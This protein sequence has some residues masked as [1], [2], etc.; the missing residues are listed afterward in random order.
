M[1][2][3]LAGMDGLLSA[4]PARALARAGH[5]I[6]GVVV[7]ERPRGR[8]L[9]PTGAAQV[10]AELGLALVTPPQAADLL[11]QAGLAVVACFPRRLEPVW[12]EAPALG[13]INVHPSALPA[14]R[15][16]APLFWQLR[17]GVRVG[18]VS[19]HRLTPALDAGDV[20]ASVPVDLG[21][22]LEQSELETRLG[23]A[24]GSL[25]VDLLGG[26]WPESRPQSAGSYQPWPAPDD[27]ILPR[28]W[29]AAHALRFIRGAA[30]YGPFRL[31]GDDGP[32]CVRSARGW[33][34]AAP[35]PLPRMSA[36]RFAQGVLLLGSGDAH[37]LIR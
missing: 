30:G 18:A 14:Y 31:E 25:L 19:I 28:T 22:D 4:L 37:P 34:P 2:L 11:A 16:P 5:Q 36:V 9:L 23:R 17:D 27:R 7:P 12:W 32:L 15:G 21:Q 26:D 3:V 24:A 33:A 10:A 8:R 6:L 13:A 35:D 20:L 1:R 29:T